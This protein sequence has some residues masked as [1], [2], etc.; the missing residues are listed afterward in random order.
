MNISY[1]L[2]LIVLGSCCCQGVLS[3]P[4]LC[5]CYFST[6]TTQVVCSN[7]S[8]SL[9]PEHGLPDNTTFLSIEFTN[10]SS[11]SAHHLK[12]TPLL[13]ELHL[14]GNQLH[15]LPADLLS[16]LPHLH[17]LDLTGNQL[18][19]LP[20]GVF[21]HAPLRVLVL[22]DN[23]LLTADAHWLPP[24]SS[25]TWLDLAQNR[26]SSVPTALLQNLPHLE[27]LHLSQN[28]LEKLPAGALNSLTCLKRLHLDGNKL[29]SLDPSSFQQIPNLKDLFLQ[30]NQLEKLPPGLLQ[31][32]GQ[33]DVLSVS[34]NRLRSLAPGLLSKLPSLG[35]SAGQGVDLSL[36]PWQCEKDVAYLWEWLRSHQ[37]ISFSLEDVQCAAPEALKGRPVISLTAGEWGGSS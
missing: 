32:L 17:T 34:G 29:R 15:Q 2:T 35:S 25:L 30:E 31:G 12:A 4:H 37:E 13:Q 33:L 10:I 18:E 16:G 5:T 3:C 21:H 24:N 19:H 1:L 27:I 20:P 36:N 22:R 11:I 26:L 23:R 6:N 9:F 8:L 14:S 28:W 7:S